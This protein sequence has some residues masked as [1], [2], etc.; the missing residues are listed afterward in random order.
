[1]LLIQQSEDT[2]DLEVSQGLGQ[3]L[4]L[5]RSRLWID[6]VQPADEALYTC[7][8]ENSYERRSA[9]TTVKVTSNGDS[10]IS[11]GNS[12]AFCATK[13]AFGEYYLHTITFM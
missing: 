1:M 8:A 3:G 10:I 5:T 13:K 2:N 12:L 9:S 11:S 4:A 6:C 7:V